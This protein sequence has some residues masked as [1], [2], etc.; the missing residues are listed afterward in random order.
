MP[1]TPSLD[2]LIPRLRE[3]AADPARR[4]YV[5]D[6]QFSRTV[7][8]MDLG[9]M[10]SMGRTLGGL[11][12]QSLRAQREGRID[13]EAV[14]MADDIE[15]QMHTPVDDGL[16]A[17]ADEATVQAAEAV[18]RVTLPA[19]MR[20]VYTEVADGGF[21]PGYGLLPL[22]RVVREYGV[23]RQPD[24]MPRGRE[25][26]AGLL[27]VVSQHPGWDCVEASTGRVVSWDPED[28]S[29]RSSEARFQASFQELAPSVE[30]W[31]AEWVESPTAEQE[32][33]EMM[34]RFQSSDYQ[35][36]QAREARAMI[37]GMSLEERRAMGLPD[38]GWEE[39]VWGGIGWPEDDAEATSGR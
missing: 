12:K 13:P 35:V 37:R 9:G 10:L 38:E 20:R 30:A 16:P 1:A 39:V 29:E 22:A 32:R 25:W 5:R 7:T 15:R 8:S 26:P 14:A 23:L 19:A 17:P 33:D 28:L 4:T 6:N 21:G 11:L 31:L 34:A 24:M 27:P 36:Q 2:E 18:L 3:R